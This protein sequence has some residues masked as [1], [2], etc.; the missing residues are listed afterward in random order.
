[1]NNKE[2]TSFFLVW[3]ILHVK[4]KYVSAPQGA[5]FLQYVM[6]TFFLYFLKHI[7]NICGLF[8]DTNADVVS[9]SPPVFTLL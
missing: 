5:K 3:E 2:K 1:M 6:K 9:L 4:S 7:F 8:T